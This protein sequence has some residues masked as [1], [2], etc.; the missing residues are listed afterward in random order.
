MS[1]ALALLEVSSLARGAIVADAVAKRAPVDLLECAP[2]SPGKYLVLFAGGVA[3]VQESMDAGAASAG[4]LLLDKL[5][6]PQAHA[7]VLPAVRAGARGFTHERKT[8]P[9][10]IVELVSVAAALRAADAACKAAAVRLQLL[11]LARGIGG[12][13]W[14]VV[15]GDLHSVEAAVLAATQAAGAGLVAGAEILAAP[16]ADLAGRVF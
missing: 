16:H 4:D 13:G 2:V 15:R 14:F 10:G 3:E 12:K 8:E 11:H 9:A 5:L 6:L 7:Q 1:E